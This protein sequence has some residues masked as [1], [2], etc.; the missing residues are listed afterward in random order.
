MIRESAIEAFFVRTARTLGCLVYKLHERGAP[1]R[2]LITPD[3]RAAFVEL[4]RPGAK[5]R[6]EQ[7]YEHERLRARGLEVYVV[8]SKSRALDALSTIMY[9]TPGVLKHLEVK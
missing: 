5:P 1:D 2:L 4:K 9:G 7:E 3:N 8:D 6:A